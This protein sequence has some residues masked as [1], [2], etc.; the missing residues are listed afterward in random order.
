[1]SDYSYVDGGSVFFRLK[2]GQASLEGV[3]YQ[4]S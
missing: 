3:P 4:A 1:M 2:F